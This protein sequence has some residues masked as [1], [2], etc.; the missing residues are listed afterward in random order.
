MTCKCAICGYERGITEDFNKWPDIPGLQTVFYPVTKFGK[1]DS[2]VLNFICA[3]CLKN[4]ISM[5]VYV[6]TL[7]SGVIVSEHAVLRYI[8][9]INSG[10]RDKSTG[11]V[12]VLRAFSKARKIRFSEDIMMMRT[13]N[14]DYNEM[15]Y[16]WNN[17][18]IFVVSKSQ[19]RT[20]VTVE[21][22]WKKS[23]NKDFF[24]ADEAYMDNTRTP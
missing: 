4:A 16:Y 17:D 22:L 10:I 6:K 2:E 9:R 20:I 14:N 1:P 21:K 5:R 19:P 8:E 7:M 18:I 15:E 13:K 23:L 24:Y 12:A 3:R 11:R